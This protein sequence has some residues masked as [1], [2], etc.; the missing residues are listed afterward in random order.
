[1]QTRYAQLNSIDTT[2]MTIFAKCPVWDPSTNQPY[3][4]RDFV[5]VM[6]SGHNIA[7]NTDRW[8]W[9]TTPTT[10]IWDTWVNLSSTDKTNQVSVPLTT[11]AVT[12]SLLPAYLF[13]Y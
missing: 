3:A 5:S 2:L 8:N 12:Y 10:G 11:R 13:N 7:N 4:N 6:G 1:L 9:I